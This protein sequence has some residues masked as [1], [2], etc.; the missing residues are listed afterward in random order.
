MWKKFLKNFK[1]IVLYSLLGSIII[2]VCLFSAFY[3]LR[4]EQKPIPLERQSLA[5]HNYLV[6]VDT[7]FK[8][9]EDL[10]FNVEPQIRYYVRNTRAFYGSNEDLALHIYSVTYKAELFKNNWAPNIED[11][12]EVSITSLK[13]NKWIRKL[14]HETK[15]VFVANTKAIQVTSIYKLSN[16]N[17]VQ[18]VV[19]VP[20]RTST[21]TFRFTFKDNNRMQQTVDRIIESIVINHI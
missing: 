16:E 12:A 7:P 1:T 6:T 10:G 11:M 13:N 19:H 14:E 17:M 20:T 15:N 4:L 3:A 8:M 21:W 9:S 18:R 2:A 5:A